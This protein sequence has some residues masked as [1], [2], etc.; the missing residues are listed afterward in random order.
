MPAQDRV[1]SLDTVRAF[2]LLLGVCFHA[3]MSFVPGMLPGIWVTVDTTP[4]VTLGQVFFVSHIFRMSLFFV[5]A[6]FFARML[7]MRSGPRGFWVNRLK[8]IAVPLI[9]GWCVSFPLFMVVQSWGLA[10]M[11]NGHLPAAAAKP[12]LPP[13]FFPFLH[14]WFL[15][16]LLLLYPLVLLLRRAFVWVDRAGA[17][18]AAADRALTILFATPAAV[19]LAPI[20][21]GAPL[22]LT[23]FLRKNWLYWAGIPAQDITYIPQLTVLIGFGTAMIAGWLFHRRVDL[24]QS[25]GKRWIAHLVVAVAATVYCSHMAGLKFAYLPAPQDS[26]RALF[27]ASYAVALWSWVFAIIGASVCYWSGENRIRRYIADSSYWIYLAH[28]PVVAALDIVV[29]G[30]PVHWAVKYGFVLAVS[31][32]LLFASYHFLVRPTFIGE[33]LNGRKYPRRQVPV[34]TVPESTGTS[35]ASL[36]SVTRRYGNTVALNGVS[37]SLAPGELVAL[38]GPNGAGKTSAIGLWLGLAEPQEG[39]CTLLGGSPLEVERRRGIG[40]MMQDVT[41][42]PGLRVREL[43]AQTASYYPDPMSVDEAMAAAHITELAFRSYD[44]LSGGQKRQVQFALAICGRPSVL[45]LDEPTVGLDIGAR[46][47]LWD[48]IRK[49][50]ESGCSVLL[51]THYLEEAEALADRVV[52]LARGRVIASGTVDDI[53]ANVS[54]R[55]I[56]CESIISAQDL[57]S[58]PGVISAAKTGGRL[59]MTVSDAEGVLRRLLASDLNVAHIEVQQAGLTEAFV[60]LTKSE[61]SPQQEAA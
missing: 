51:T 44:K 42:A 7:Y 10:Q 1:H 33:W 3:S 56:R 19:G 59:V 5:M 49:L 30:W 2:A 50:R 26:G 21:L 17:L 52:V 24:L 6:G 22:A 61:G 37:L 29:R 11:F 9:V 45:F 55:L 54:R 34:S 57:A 14:L 23:L 48:A 13:G 58:W 8:R 4:S 60:E 28:L 32:G 12:Q 40:V 15:Y 16:A 31:F 35:V 39:R 47:N 38:L 41:L 27:A 36:D 20:L 53:R 18:R 43:I 46:E 25:F